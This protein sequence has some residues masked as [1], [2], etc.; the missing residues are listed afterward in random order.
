MAPRCAERGGIWDCQS[1]GYYLKLGPDVGWKRFWRMAMKGFKACLATAVISILLFVSA[2]TAKDFCDSQSAC[3]VQA[4]TMK[5]AADMPVKPPMSK[6]HGDDACTGQS[7][8]ELR[9]CQC[10]A[11][12]TPDFPCKFVNATALHPA[13]CLCK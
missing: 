7:G 5:L 1:L 10:E 8:V 9:K 3:P 2:A 12:G 6:K 11:Q 13:R 4:G